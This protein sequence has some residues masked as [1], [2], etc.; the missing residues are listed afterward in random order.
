MYHTALQS[1]AR[2]AHVS[3]IKRLIAAGSDVNVQ[4]GKYGNALQSARMVDDCKAVQLLLDA[5]AHIDAR[6]GMYGTALQAACA[7]GF[8]EVVQALL[9]AGADVNMKGG[10][11][12]NA[13]VAAAANGHSRIL[14]RLLDKGADVR[15]WR[16]SVEA[17]STSHKQAIQLLL[18]AGA[19]VSLD[20][21]SNKG[22]DGEVGQM[23]SRKPGIIVE[24]FEGIE[25]DAVRQAASAVKFCDECGMPIP[26][27]AKYYHCRICLDD[28]WDSCESCVKAG[29]PCRDVKHRLSKRQIRNG[30]VVE[31]DD[32]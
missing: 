14:K 28:D 24:Y 23:G 32:N 26:D 3:V 8:E 4:G 15:G 17:S 13:V 6:S 11:H 27:G 9:N 19:E 16:L 1:A 31:L 18:E 5:G 30:L 12:G 21:G 25:D 10:V 2:G 29:F 22:S 20:G 7:Q